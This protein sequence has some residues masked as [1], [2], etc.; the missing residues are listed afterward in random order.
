MTQILPLKNLSI[1][2]SLFIFS[3]LWAVAQQDLPARGQHGRR[4]LTIL[5]IQEAPVLDGRL[6]EQIWQDTP[7]ADQFVQRDPDEGMPATERTQVR[8]LYDAEN[9]YFGIRCFDS[10]AER[11]LATELRRDNN[12]DNDDSF[13]IILDTFHDHRNAF[14]FRI[15]PEGTQYD[16]LIT[17]EGRDVNADWDEKWEVEARIDDEGWTAEIKIPLKTIRFSASSERFGIDFERVIRRKNESSY[18]NNYSRNFSFQQISQA[19]HLQGLEAVV[20]GLRLRI[21]PYVNGRIITQGA[22]ERNTNFLADV[23]LEN[24]KYSVTSGLTLDLT[25]NTDF[26]QTE[27]DSQ[28]INFDRFPVFF[29]EKREFFLEGA[30]IFEISLNA[31]STPDIKLFHSRRIGLSDGGEEIPILAGARLTGRVGEKFTLGVLGVRTDE[32]QGRPADNFTV[33]RLKRDILS[34]S[35]VGMFFTGRRADGGY[36]NRVVGVD[37]NLIFFEHLKV[38][39]ILARSFT[40]GVDDRQWL[41]SLQTIWSDDFLLAGFT[42]FE[43]GENFQTDLG[44]IKREAVRSYGPRFAISP[45]PSSDRIRQLSFGVRLEH[46][47]SV[48]DNEL[49]TEI[50]HFDNSIQF[51]DGSSFAVNPHRRVEVLDTP[52]NL[53]GGL[54]VSP[55]TYTWWHSNFEYRLNPARMVSGN[56]EYRYEWDYYGE[57]GKRHEWVLAPVVKLNSMFSFQVTYGI[58]RIELAG[59]EPSTFHL[60]NNSFNFAFSRKWLTSTVLQYNSDSDV[61]GVNFRL[62]YIYRPGDDLFI[63]FNEFRDRSGATTDLDRQLIV[64]FT[65]SF[66]F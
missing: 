53:P 19:G 25:V 56:L 26:A 11:I 18:W 27:V 43:V 28:V 49:F 37:Q 50:Y 57:G 2:L 29:P 45:R 32:S 14:L 64:K 39:G 65:H 7:V 55:G 23:G 66:D 36:F 42:Y 46:L 30:G 54:V 31:G 20:S 52:L 40:E 47:R 44:F 62:N 10:G 59:R 58:N 13:A 4:S 48:V 6:D 22:E 3:Q 8:A 35:A 38:A 41:G 34:R 16:A 17:D 33:F 63:V 15:N 61:V 60:L 9:L 1:T 5:Q 12:F 24:L 51:Q 21:K